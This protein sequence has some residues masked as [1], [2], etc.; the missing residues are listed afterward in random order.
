M[1]I[2]CLQP[3][4]VQH[5]M[6]MI[7]RDVFAAIAENASESTKY[8]SAFGNTELWVI[9]GCFARYARCPVPI[10]AGIFHEVFWVIPQQRMHNAHECVI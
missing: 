6:G 10:G 4:L 3:I 5:M 1:F 8:S 7:E 9:L 2:V